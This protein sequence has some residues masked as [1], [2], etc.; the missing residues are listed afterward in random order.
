M[1]YLHTNHKFLLISAHSSLEIVHY[2]S[3]TPTPPG[4]PVAHIGRISAA[5]VAP[6]ACRTSRHHSTYAFV[7]GPSPFNDECTRL[8][9][10][11]GL[12]ASRVHVFH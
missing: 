1:F 10:T 12:D 11:N 6:L 8:L 5:I 9:A 2:L 7:C 4:W 3:A